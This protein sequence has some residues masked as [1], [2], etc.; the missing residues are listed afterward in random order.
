MTKE[1]KATILVVDDEA[2]NLGVLFEFLRDV[3]YKVLVAENGRR[4]LET[5]ERVCPDVILLDI[6]LPD[7]DGYEV[8]RRLKERGL[9]QGMTVIFLSVLAET[10]DIVRGFDMNAVDYITKPFQPMEVVARVEKHLILHKLRQQLEQ[11]NIQL[12]EQIEERLQAEAA[13]A[14]KSSY[15]DSILSSAT[16]D[17]IITTGLEFRI[18]YINPVAERIYGFEAV[19]AIGRVVTEICPLEIPSDR[20]NQGVEHLR[21]E[22]EH[23]YQMVLEVDGEPRDFV[24]RLSGIYDQE[25]KLIGYARFSRDITEMKRAE[26]ALRELSVMKERQRLARNLHDSMTQSIQS[27]S[28]TAKTAKYFL[29]KERIQFLPASLDILERSSQQAHKELR[30]LLHELQVVPDEETDLFEILRTRLENVEQRVDVDTHLEVEGRWYI[31]KATE[32][33]IYYIA[34]E[35]LNN[36][37]RYANADQIKISIEGMPARVILQVSDNGQGFPSA[38]S[39]QVNLDGIAQPGMG[40][41]NMLFRAEKLSGILSIDSEPGEGTTVRLEAENQK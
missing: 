18:T 32:I 3:G 17:A 9:T 23:R 35:A 16:E 36:A 20:M 1:T 5:V 15:L 12:Q 38:L 13:L 24:Q 8:Y 29:K 31:D 22:G 40:L 4:A 30:L 10:D 11:Q 27:L 19:E 34:Q 39:G 37:L 26:E 2:A 28:L 25:G 21:N 7:I 33:E 41:P 6:K 14:E